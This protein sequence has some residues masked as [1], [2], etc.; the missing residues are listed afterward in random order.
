MEKSKLIQE[1]IL[2]HTGFK[3]SVLKAKEIYEDVLTSF[4]DEIV[5]ENGLYLKGIGRINLKPS[6]ER[7]VRNP[8]TGEKIIKKEG[9]RVSFKPSKAL[10][11]SANE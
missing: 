11:I 1:L 8:K 10:K 3:V 9:F 6:P 7:M 5:T 2:K 4:A